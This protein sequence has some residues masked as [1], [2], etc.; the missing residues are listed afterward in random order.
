MFSNWESLNVHG[1]FNW[2]SC[3]VFLKLE[4]G[5]NFL[6]SFINFF[7]LSFF[8][9]LYRSFFLSIIYL[10]FFLCVA[11]W[12]VPRDFWYLGGMKDVEFINH[13]QYWKISVSCRGFPADC[14]SADDQF[15]MADLRPKGPLLRLGHLRVGELHHWHLCHPC[16]ALDLAVQFKLYSGVRAWTQIWVQVQLGSSGPRCTKWADEA[17]VST[18]AR[19]SAR[20]W[21]SPSLN[22]HEYRP[23]GHWP[24]VKS[25]PVGSRDK[26][27]E[28]K[29]LCKLLNQLS[30]YH[31]SW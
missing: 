7:F 10:S 16:I 5:H 2:E 25:Y 23:S 4:K 22:P 27:P 24:W 3:E 18:R 12:L 31:F 6:Y 14:L 29:D 30:T 17:A 19:A 15:S 26:Y 1:F 20:A 9:W 11:L 21:P 13:M 28:L 8:L